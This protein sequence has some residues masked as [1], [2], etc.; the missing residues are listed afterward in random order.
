MWTGIPY[1]I[2]GTNWLATDIR[3]RLRVNRNYQTGYSPV[4]MEAAPQNNNVPMYE[5]SM[6]DLMTIRGSKS[7][8]SSVLDLIQVVPNP[9]YAASE[10]ETN[11]LDNRIKVVNLPDE[12][13]I[14]IYSL[15][16]TLIRRIEKSTNTT[17]SVDWD[18]KNFNGIPIASGLYIFHVN[19]PGIGERVIKWYGAMRPIDLESF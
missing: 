6:D 18:L 11:Q 14:S 7:T 3:I 12:C 19:A 9:Y 5:F 16:G 1:H 15:N 13:T 2:D 8:A 10:Y 17:T 4:N